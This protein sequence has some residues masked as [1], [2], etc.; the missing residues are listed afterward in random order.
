MSGKIN[1][2]VI[3]LRVILALML[4]VMIMDTF[5]SS[6]SALAKPICDAI[7]VTVDGERV[8]FPDQ[9]PILYNGHVLVP[10]RAVFEAMG[11]DVSWNE[12]TQKVTLLRNDW[13]AKIAIGDEI[14]E[15]AYM[16]STHTRFYSLGSY[17][18]IINDRAM[19]PLTRNLEN[20]G[21]LFNWDDTLS[22]F[23]L[24]SSVVRRNLGT[25][26][27]NDADAFLAEAVVRG[28]MNVT[29]LSI[30][31]AGLNDL[32]PLAKLTN[33]RQLSVQS[34]IVVD[35]SS[36]TGLAYLRSL[37][38]TAP[39]E[40][41][42]API[43]E[44]I[45]YSMPNLTQLSLAGSGI[46]NLVPLALLTNLEELGLSGGI[47]D[48]TPLVSLENLLN[49]GL[50]SRYFGDIEAIAEIPNLRQLV[51]SIDSGNV[52][53][54]WLDFSMFFYL[55][56]LDYLRIFVHS[57]IMD[58]ATMNEMQAAIQTALPYTRV[59]VVRAYG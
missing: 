12:T 27:M 16:S 9:E 33:L 45:Y 58:I 34:G 5:F 6:S 57:T 52:A 8:I 28:S 18:R 35:V 19:I 36:L 59:Q 51:I 49:L 32:S 23:T 55:S 1:N 44:M 43:A 56:E 24:Q 26:Y 7:A 40:H 41:G 37:H 54:N 42:I 2:K 22:E 3:N 4:F 17:A 46:Y 39:F 53:R 30:R 15:I 48:I 13:R 25:W 29:H 38:I 50:S 20:L 47:Y 31:A 11:F 14:F 10:V 21:I